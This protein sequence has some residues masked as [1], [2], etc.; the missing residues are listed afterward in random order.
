MTDE[1]LNELMPSEGYTV[2]HPP[3]SYQPIHTPARKLAATPAPIVGA[4][5]FMIQEDEQHHREMDLPSEIPGVGTL[6]F[7]KQA[8]MDHFSKL[9][10]GKDETDL[11]NEELKEL[12]RSCDCC[13]RSRT[14][15]LQCE[16]RPCAKSQTKPETLVQS[17]YFKQILPLLMSTTL[18]D[19][20]RHLL[21]KVIDR[22]LYKL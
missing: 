22:I 9:L 4:D 11:D 15:R 3:P 6:P 21:V 19:Q 20:E 10:D 16:S 13:S 14:V 5:G 18:E 8:D 17:H 7:F 12:T 2:L 1:E